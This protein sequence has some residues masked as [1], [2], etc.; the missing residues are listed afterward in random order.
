MKKPVRTTDSNDPVRP[1]QAT[2]A[3]MSSPETLEAFWPTDLF[4]KGLGWVIIAR[5]KAGGRKVVVGI[6]LIDVFCRGVKKAYHEV[7]TLEDYHQC[8]RKH[9]L[10]EF[11]MEQIPPSRARALVEQVVRFA[12]ALGLPAGANYD[13]ASRIFAQI[14]A[15]K[16]NESFT[17]GKDGKPFYISGP[18]DTEAES[19]RAIEQLARRCGPGNFHY[20]VQMPI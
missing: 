15:S 1:N 10:S 2:P 8:I 9:Y 19:R 4:D 13:K 12:M 11:S 17:F 7:C 6:F 14:P 18:N 3:I 5:I 20:I 16:D